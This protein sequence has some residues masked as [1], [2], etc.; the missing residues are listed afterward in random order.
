MTNLKFKPLIDRSFFIIW[1]PTLM[2]LAAAT[3]ISF[4]S[5][6]ALLIM[7][8]TDV[9]VIYF[10]FSSL[11][12]YAELRE[13]SLYI[14]FGFI[15]KREIP[16]SSIRELKKERKIIAET[17]LSLKNALDHV[18]VKYNKFDNVAVSVKD[19]DTFISELKKRIQTNSNIPS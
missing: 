7:L 11:F 17:M 14:K 19:N 5:P 13:D 3:V 9:F 1:L 2:L 8:A 6:V 16:Y 18:T 12:A 4:S 10:L 15:L